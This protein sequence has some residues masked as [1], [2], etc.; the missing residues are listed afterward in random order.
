VGVHCAPHAALNPYAALGECPPT[1]PQEA[2]QA[3]L[4]A[5]REGKDLALIAIYRGEDPRQFGTTK[6]WLGVD[7]A[8]SRIGV[9]RA[10]SWA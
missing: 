2:A 1:G 10:E 6:A 3:H 9:G 4:F 8:S 5:Q 7:G